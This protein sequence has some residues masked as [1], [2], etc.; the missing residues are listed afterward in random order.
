MNYI[1]IFILVVILV[2]SIRGLQNGLI[3]E[4]ISI[5][6]IIFGIYLAAIFY[7]DLG[8]FFGDSLN[9]TNNAVMEIVSF[10]LILS[11]I[12]IL[13][14]AIGS[15]LS[16]FVAFGA[17]TLF[18][19]FGGFVFAFL[20]YAVI[21]SVIVYTIAQ[22][23]FL[24]TYINNTVSKTYSYPYLYGLGDRVLSFKYV[25][26]IYKRL[27]QNSVDNISSKSNQIKKSLK[28]N[29]NSTEKLIEKNS[30]LNK[31]IKDISNNVKE[32]LN[33]VLEN[34]KENIE[35]TFNSGINKLKETGNAVLDAGENII[36]KGKEKL[37]KE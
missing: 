17:F 33:P 5:A 32:G 36:N 19:Y 12:W 15:I 6:G 9:I 37:N 28:Q 13:S 22:V 2:L 4:L 14:V 20:K 24:K 21:L 7:R 8:A 23:S 34:S 27:E 35:N 10:I 31:D 16:K 30:D 3:H 26:D 25:Q 29:Q 1:D 18:N 11:V